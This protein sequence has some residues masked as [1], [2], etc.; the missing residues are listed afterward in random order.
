MRRG[1]LGA[2]RPVHDWSAHSLMLAATG[3]AAA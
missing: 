3:T 1:A 2:P